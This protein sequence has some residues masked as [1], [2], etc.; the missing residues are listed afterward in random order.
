MYLL[1]EQGAR[2]KNHSKIYQN[3]S[4]QYSNLFTSGVLCRC[5]RLTRRT[6]CLF[7]YS[8][9]GVGKSCPAT[10]EL[11]DDPPVVPT[12]AEQLAA[13]QAKVRECEAEIERE[14]AKAAEDARKAEELARCQAEEVNA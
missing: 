6:L 14:A 8:D 1:K 12:L 11:L 13:A 5:F 7:H 3:A 4:G 2:Y 10:I 9:A